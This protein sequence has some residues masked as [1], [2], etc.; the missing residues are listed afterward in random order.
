MV[1]KYTKMFIMNIIFAMMLFAFASCKSSEC[2]EKNEETGYAEVTTETATICEND[3]SSYINNLTEE[4]IENASAVVNNYYADNEI[5][6]FGKVI[7]I[8]WIRPTAKE[9]G[10]KHYVEAF[11]IDDGPGYIII[12]EVEVKFENWHVSSYRSICLLYSDEN[13]WEVISETMY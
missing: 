10:Y 7:D 8:G 13:V 4:D 11:K 5:D 9:G 2:K 12:F 3:Y 1:K 6:G